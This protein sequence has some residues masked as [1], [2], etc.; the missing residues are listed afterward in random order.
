MGG[1]LSRTKGHSYEREIAKKFRHLY[2]KS[3]RML[4]YQL[5]DCN[6]VDVIAGPFSIQC[7]RYKDYAPI[8][9]IEEIKAPSQQIHALVTKGDRK[10]DIICLK[11]RD[12]LDILEDIGVAFE[13]SK[14]GND[15]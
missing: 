11:L 7:K 2:P 14:L 8:S 3:K 5:E 4:E 9:K 15:K 6:G 12:F 1:K 10:E 13:G